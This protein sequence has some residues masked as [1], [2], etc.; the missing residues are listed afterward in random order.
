MLALSRLQ[1][2][3]YSGMRGHEPRPCHWSFSQNKGWLANLLSWLA[4]LCTV[5]NSV[6]DS[7][8]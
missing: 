2:P 6:W 1:G 4:N 3:V 8:S 5:Q 7:S